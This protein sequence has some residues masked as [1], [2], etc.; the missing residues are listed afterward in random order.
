MFDIQEELKKLPDKPGVYIMKDEN[1]EIIYVG[2]AVVLKNRVRQYFQSLSNQT[3]KVRAM[4]A[5]IKE[6]EYIVT[7]TELEALILEC[8]LIKK[9][10][11]KFNILLKDDKNYPYIKVTMNE[12][13]PRILMTRRVE[14]DGA[15]YFG[16][17]T[18]AY[19]VRET[20]DLV[21]K[22]FPVKTCSKVLPRDIGKGRPCLNYHIY[23]CL[24]PCQGNVSK[25]EY[26]F[27][28]QDVCN[29]L[30]GRQEDIIK[31]LE[32]DMKEAA[33]N[34]EFERA[35]RIRDKINSLKHIAEKQKIISTA[36]EDQDVIAFAKSETDSCIQVFFIRGGK[37]IGREHFI[38]EG[39][40]DVSDSELMTAF[41]KQFY[42]SAAYVPGQIILQEDIDEMEIIEKWLSGKRGTKTYIKVPRRGEKQ[43]L[44]E[45][46][47]K[48]ALIELNQFKERIKKEAALAKEG[49][50]KLKELLNLDRLPRRIEAYD[51]SNTGSTEIVGSMVVFE[52]GSPKKSDYRRFKI[53]SIN[54]QND[55]QSMQEVIFRRLKRA[56]KEMTEK[57]EGGGKDVGEKGAGFGT[58]PDV[59]LVDGGTGHVNAVR[60]VLEELD[61][62][63]PVYGMVKDDNHRTR[64]LVTGER[65][66]DLSKDIVLLRFVTAIQ[67]EA[68]RFALEYNRKLRAKRYSGSVLDNIEGVGPKRKKELIRHFGSVKAIKE[69][70]PG[71]IAKVKGI[72]RD[73][74][75]KIYDYFRQ[76]E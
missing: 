70:E 74:A 34:L 8:N 12:D 1:G 53:K 62:N 54:V 59:L 18:S 28:M 19:A 51:I 4:V 55:Y 43:K 22:L 45:M 20:I 63:I 10:R 76:Q 69:A 21:K 60:S 23:Q 15:K 38:L 72:S 31:K 75:Q 52:N 39:T 49:M 9:H 50:E 48:N 29:F 36:M 33:D 40:S 41:V 56:Q 2:K 46:V 17:Y 14:K 6:F 16:P 64:G 24:G 3:P 5:H 66:F 47:S 26:R 42:S 61:F 67:D 30:G 32:K 58:L 25:E 37:L 7:D 73:L 44:V 11:P 65:E 68:H 27:M 13:F 57:D 71:E 35:A